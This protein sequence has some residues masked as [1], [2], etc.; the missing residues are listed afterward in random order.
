MKNFVFMTLFAAV[1]CS[2]S[3]RLECAGECFRTCNFLELQQGGD[4]NEGPSPCDACEDAPR[5][6]FETSDCYE[7]IQ[8][9]VIAN[10]G[11]L[12]CYCAIPNIDESYEKSC[13]MVIENHGGEKKYLA[14][15]C[16]NE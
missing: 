4:H 1:A 11:F 13:E 3:E 16:F 9:S 2:P 6:P 7:Y 10:M 15:Y 8:E 14:S 5:K 12:E